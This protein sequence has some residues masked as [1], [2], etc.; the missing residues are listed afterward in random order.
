MPI[1]RSWARWFAPLLV[2]ILVVLFLMG[3]PFLFDLPPELRESMRLSVNFYLA[4][5]V[6][7]NLV[8]WAVLRSFDI[9]AGFHFKVSAYE[10]LSKEPRALAYYLGSRLL[11]V[12]IGNAIVAGYVF[13]SVRF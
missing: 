12:G 13:A 2:L 7:Y 10:A 1:N 6:A 8:V 5:A 11:A 9:L 3:V 4:A